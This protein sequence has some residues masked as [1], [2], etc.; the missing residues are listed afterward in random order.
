[1]IK[2]NIAYWRSTM[3]EGKGIS[4]AYL[5]RQ[6]GVGR[7]FVTKM[8]KGTGKAGGELMFRVA[9]YFKQPIEAIFRQDDGPGAVPAI[10][11]AKTIPN[12]QS[13]KA[14]FASVSAKPMRPSLA[15]PPARPT[16]MERTTD[17]S[18]VGPTAKVVAPPVAW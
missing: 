14:S 1:M 7:S 16:G 9:R 8:E 5:A 3:D 13:S 10:F 18:L 4:R 6:I 12:R 17:K 11:C 15:T 2:N